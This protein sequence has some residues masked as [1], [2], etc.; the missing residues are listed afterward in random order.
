MLIYISISKDEGSKVIIFVCYPLQP[1]QKIIAIFQVLE[2]LEINIVLPT[3]I[4]HFTEVHKKCRLR[5][6]KAI[7]IF[8]VWVRVRVIE[9]S[10]Y[11]YTTNIL[12]Y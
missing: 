7:C 4:V 3:N 10:H 2:I 6:D 8:V 5:I 11:L 12:T 1:L 9:N